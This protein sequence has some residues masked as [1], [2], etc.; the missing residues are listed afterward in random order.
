MNAAENAVYDRINE[1]Y[2]GWSD[3][4]KAD[5]YSLVVDMTPP[6][7]ITDGETAAIMARA[8]RKNEERFRG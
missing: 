6:W 5:L 8:L 2:P 4:R 3:E 1:G 7:R